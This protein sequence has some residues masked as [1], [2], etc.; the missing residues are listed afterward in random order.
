MTHRSIHLNTDLVGVVFG[1]LIIVLTI[2]YTG[3][4]QR[5]NQLIYDNYIQLGFHKPDKD[6]VIIAI[7]DKS[8]SKLG[9][10]PWS[11]ILYARL[12]DQL[13]TANV[14]S[15]GFDIVFPKDRFYD[16]IGNQAFAKA[17]RDNGKV[18][19]PLLRNS[20]DAQITPPL[21]AL[22]NEAAR[23]AVIETD[24]DS[25]GLTRAV[26]LHAGSGV[27]KWPTLGLAMLE[28]ESRESV[29]ENRPKN[30]L[31][32]TKSTLNWVQKER[33]LISFSGPRGSFTQLS[34][35]DVLTDDTLLDSL[36]DKHVLIGVTA[37]GLSSDLSTP[38]S[39]QTGQM[40][41]VEFHANVLDTLLQK[42]AIKPL[43]RQ[44]GTLLSIILILMPL[45]LYPRTA[46]G[47]AFFSAII[48]IVFTFLLTAVLLTV[49][50]RWFPPTPSVLGLILGFPLWSW[51]RMESMVKQLFSAKERAEVTVRS[52]ADGVITIDR[53]ENIRY[54]NPVAEALTGYSLKEALGL[55]L[56]KVFNT[57]NTRNSHNFQTSSHH[58]MSPD[59]HN[60]FNRSNKSKTFVNRTGTKYAI[61]T[62]SGEI[63]DAQGESDG[64]VLAISD[65]SE[66]KEILDK[67]AHQ[68]SHDELTQLPNRALLMDRLHQAVTRAQ[69]S[70]KQIA[71]MFVDLDGFKKINDGLGHA[72]GDILIKLAAE[73]LS[74]CG[75]KGDTVARLGGDEFVLVLEGWSKSMRVFAVANKVLKQLAQPFWV[76][77]QEAFIS[78]SIGISLYPKDGDDA[79]ALL[80]TAD[81][82]MYHAKEEG[83]NNFQFFSSS[84]NRQVFERLEL[85]KQL[86]YAMERDELEIHYQPQ[87]SLKTGKIVGVEAL[88][89]WHHPKLGM[90]PPSRFIALAEENGLILPLGE[91]VTRRACR[92]AAEWQQ[93][94]FSPIQVAVNLSPRQ[95]SQQDLLAFLTGILADTGLDPKLLK[96]EIT[97]NLLVKDYQRANKCLRK[98][99]ELGGKVSID[100]FGTGY[101]SLSYL[102]SMP[103]DQI[104]ID[105]SF[106][107]DIATNKKDAAI[108]EAIITMAHGL[109]LDVIAE[110][111]ETQEQMQ[112]LKQLKCDEIQGFYYSVPLEARRISAL[113]SK[114]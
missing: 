49:F 67:I 38:V 114:N 104:K 24:L 62:V 89:R 72:A 29:G 40:S 14:K 32:N 27:A 33:I 95:F 43:P 20:W 54:M 13:T 107:N 26:Y 16:A 44:W 108:A 75:R 109:E 63:R 53:N 96:L 83:K 61:R 42:T 91:W 98:F 111:V 37:R 74:Q 99:R 28:L 60:R 50:H 59:A 65:V 81:T 87:I 92:Q 90:I 93:Q 103:V 31:I 7:D 10:W 80:K 64:M 79:E 2:F 41:A 88:S 77:N 57:H 97:E 84:A 30:G 19:L 6:I 21:S 113:L 76:D 51:L 22:S 35:S 66:T 48:L 56:S 23:L 102:K 11:R 4:L 3:S 8:L 69:R 46:P 39:G 70:K 78:A 106:V 55:P 52:I 71:V 68:A 101:S 34:F 18:I 1:L 47:R 73:R 85:E 82:A 58:F 17:I 86:R 15:V 9:H 36:H 94:G 5:L 105:R 25:D 110:G 112:V 12:L 45:F 100:D